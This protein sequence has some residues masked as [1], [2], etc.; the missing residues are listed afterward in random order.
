LK[1]RNK[2]KSQEAKLLAKEYKKMPNREQKEDLHK[3]VRH[4]GRNASHRATMG[5]N[6]APKASVRVF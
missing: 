6:L 5:T 2:Q 1:T 3:N 4:R